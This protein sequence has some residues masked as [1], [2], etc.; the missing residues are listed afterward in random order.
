MFNKDN[1]KD[2]LI[3]KVN[4]FKQVQ[5]SNKMY[6]DVREFLLDNYNYRTLLETIWNIVNDFPNNKCKECGEISKFYSFNVG[7][8]PFCN[9]KC[10]NVFKGKDKELSEKIARGVTKFNQSA[11]DEFWTSRTETHRET[12]RNQTEEHK[13]KKKIEKSE[14]MKRMH[15]ERCDE[16]K[17]I[18]YN[19]ISESVKNSPSAKAQRIE[20]AKLGA[21]ALQFK[22]SLMTE[23]ELK[24]FN[25]RF[26]S[27]DIIGNRREEY[28]KYLKLV[29]YYT[30]K[31]LHK[32]KNIELRGEDY[33]LDHM[34]SR[35]QGF[36]DNICPKIIGN[37][38]NLEIITAK[39][40]LSKGSDCSITKEDLMSSFN[41]LKI[42]DF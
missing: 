9:V 31:E 41:E 18:I 13:E 37:N 22:R 1:I 4:T 21:A 32:V 14:R 28:K 26:G 33:H 17:N 20:R 19:K 3:E 25:S 6:D 38:N 42:G 39:E 34:Y 40:N 8:K 35:K 12:I 23:K 5:P 11:P 2:I 7:Y 36:L 10:S 16:I 27:P 15:S 29:S 30:N 24:E